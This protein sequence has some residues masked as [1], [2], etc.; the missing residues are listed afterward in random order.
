MNE[1]KKCVDYAVA[2][3]RP[4]GRP[5]KTWSEVKEKD[6]HAHKYAGMI[7]VENGES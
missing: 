5:N 1:R 3:V 4:R 6:F 2:D 7:L